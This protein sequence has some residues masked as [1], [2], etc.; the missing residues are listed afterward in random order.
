MRISNIL[1]TIRGLVIEIL[2]LYVST[3]CGNNCDK[4]K[5]VIT[6]NFQ[7]KM[8]YVQNNSGFGLVYNIYQLLM[9]IPSLD[10]SIS[11]TFFLSFYLLMFAFCKVSTNNIKSK[12]FALP[13]DVL[14]TKVHTSWQYIFV[15]VIFL[16]SSLVKI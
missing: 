5:T 16:R 11:F 10:I 12:N 9:S 3:L 4:N 8:W 15:W 2:I 14:C 13:P 1:Y 7:L 6:W